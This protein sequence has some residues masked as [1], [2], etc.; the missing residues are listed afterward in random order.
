MQNKTQ[1]FSSAFKRV[2]NEA[3]VGP[4][5]AMPGGISNWQ[6][7][8]TAR[9]RRG[10]NPP[11]SLHSTGTPQFSTG[12][13]ILEQPPEQQQAPKITPYPLESVGENLATGYESISSVLNLVK[14]SIKNPAVTPTMKKQL[15]QAETDLNTILENIENVGNNILEV[16]LSL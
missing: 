14:D 6:T 13:D 9:T 3:H 10:P 2:L 16:R 1:N 8:S 5:T 12:A 15:E 7:D 11:F 4:G